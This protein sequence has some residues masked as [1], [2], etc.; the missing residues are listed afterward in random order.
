M[1]TS[2]VIVSIIAIVGIVLVLIFLLRFVPLGLWITARTSGVRVRIS[3]LV[4]MRFR[5]VNPS[6]IVLPMI[7]VTKA[8]LDISMNE[9]EA[10]L[11]AGGSVDRV[12]DFSDCRSIGRRFHW[13]LSRAVPS[14]WPAAMCSR[15]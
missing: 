3:T 6:K 15:L 13:S 8:G 12:V 11:M 10:H 4:G 2:S 1:E 9:L 7:K 14:T 5:R